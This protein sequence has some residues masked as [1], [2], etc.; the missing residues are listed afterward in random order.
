MLRESH[1]DEH[2]TDSEMETEAERRTER[3]E[4]TTPERP[5]RWGGVGGCGGEGG[6][7]RERQREEASGQV[8]LG[9]DLDCV[10]SGKCLRPV[11]AQFSHPYSEGRLQFLKFQNCNGHEFE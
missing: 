11:W 3:S 2:R 4:Q 9:S 5:S 7:V 6:G 1:G 10:V 8:D